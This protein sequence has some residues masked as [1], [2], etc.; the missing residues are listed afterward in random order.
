MSIRNYKKVFAL[1][2]YAG[3][4]EFN[5][6]QNQL[7]EVLTPITKSQVVDG[8]LLK[9]I[10]LTA[11]ADNL[12]EH[13]LGREPLGW[14]IVRKNEAGEI[15]ESTTVNNNRDKFLLLRGSTAT[16]DTNFWIF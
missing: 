10:D 7:E 1:G 9:S 11:S 4:A 5:S 8:L 14:I 2:P 12:V 3:R 15:Y 16:T 13:K 6:S